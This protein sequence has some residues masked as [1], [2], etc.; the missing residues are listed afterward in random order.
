M[1]RAGH[2]CRRRIRV[3]AATAQRC[4]VEVPSQAGATASVPSQLRAVCGR[5]QFMTNDLAGLVGTRETAALEFKESASNRDAIAEVI[6][7]LANDLACTGGGDLLIGVTDDG[8]PVHGI[9]TSDRA[10]LTLTELRDD[11][12]ILDRPSITV[13]A[14]IYSGEPVIRIHVEPVVDTTGPLQRNCMGAP[15]ANHSKSEPRRRARPQ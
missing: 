13:Q 15:R 9:D 10:L 2:A 7:A 5:M 11:G 14:A 12:R 4:S 3:A 8:R 6:C 1:S